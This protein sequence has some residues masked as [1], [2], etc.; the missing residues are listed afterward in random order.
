MDRQQ[1][2]QILALIKVAYPNSYTKQSDEEL[3][4]T[5]SLWATQFK[6]YDFNLVALAVNSFIAEDLSGFAPNIAQIK[7]YARKLSKMPQ[8]TDE[9]I[10]IP[11]KKALSNSLYNSEKEY[12]QLPK[13]IQRCVTPG[14]LRDWARSD[15]DDLPFI[16]NEVL[17]EYRQQETR[18]TEFE[19][20]PA[21]ARQLLLEGG[22][23]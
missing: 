11:I 2:T 14:Q 13:D 18:Q 15:L 8:K 17:K 16:R 6:E 4:Q 20:L 1:T 7:N 9:E 5:I 23:A 10:W 21:K 12:E 3:R 22:N 19:L